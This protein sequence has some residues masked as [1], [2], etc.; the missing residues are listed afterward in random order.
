AAGA[1]PPAALR[2][3]AAGLA[4]LADAGGVAVCRVREVRPDA[5][6]LDRVEQVRPSPAD[7]EA[8]GRDLATTHAAG[9]QRF[10]APPPGEDGDTW[11]AALPLPAPR[12]PLPWGAFYAEH[13]VRPYL[14]RARGAGALDAAGAALVERV[15]ERLLAED[16]AL[17][18]GAQRPARLHGDLWSGNVLWSA[19]GAVLVDPAAHGGHPET[20]LA[21][22]ALFGL[23]HLERALGA[24]AEAAGSADGWRERVPL[25]Q[26]H[27]LL[28]HAALFGGGYGE[29]AVRAAGRALAL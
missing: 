24:Y 10:G 17:V 15:C 27:P 9:A 12:G 26:L 25:H 7:A 11:I 16:P 14:R 28:V 4:W 6:L 29:Q 3:E 19:R 21:M 2:A 8:F 13:R 5:L 18:A 1:A 23:P 22:L 20:D